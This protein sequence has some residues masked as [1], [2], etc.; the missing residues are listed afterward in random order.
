MR[1]GGKAASRD[2]P[3]LLRVHTEPRDLS[4]VRDD[5]ES[6]EDRKEA[7]GGDGKVISE[8]AVSDAVHLGEVEAE[9]VV[10][11]REED[12]GK[13]AALLHP[14]SDVEGEGVAVF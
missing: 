11:K 7:W 1:G 8:R 13:G 12:G 9:G 10:T 3:G 5:R 4:K 6:K 2:D 14:A